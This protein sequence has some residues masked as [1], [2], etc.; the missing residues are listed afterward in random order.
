[1][2]QHHLVVH[3]LVLRRLTVLR[4]RDVTPRMRRVTVGG[5]ELG[6]F[7]RDGL[8]LQAFASTQFDDHVKIVFNA[9][10]PAEDVVPIQLEHGIEWTDAPS[11]RARDYTPRRVAEDELDVDFVL[12]S[13]R[14]GGPAEQWARGAAPGD[15]LWIVGPKSSTVLPSDVDRMILVA[16]ETGLPAVGR[17]FDERPADVPVTA[18]LTVADDRARQDLAVGP[19]DS[20]V[21]VNAAP[22]DGAALADAVATLPDE[23]WQ[24][25]PYVWAAGESRSLLP[26]R[27]LVGRT[28]GVPKD[29]T[30]IT[31]Y[32]HV[33][34]DTDDSAAPAT[35][36]IE[37]PVAWLAVRAAVRLGVLDAIGDGATTTAAIGDRLTLPESV[38][39]PLVDV[40]VTRGV[41][42][43]T[44]GT[45]GLGSLGDDLLGDEHAREY[46]DGPF[47]DGVLTLTRLPDALRSGRSAWQESYGR[48]LAE[49]AAEDPDLAGEFEEEAARLTFLTGGIAA[50]PV[51]RDGLRVAVTGPGAEPVRRGL[52][53]ARPV[54]FVDDGA[55]LV[56]SALAGEHRTDDELR[57]HLAACDAPALVLVES[58]TP[59]A[60]GA[61]RAEEMLLRVATT[62]AAYRTAER[63]TEI[64][65]E[66]GWRTRSTRSLGWGVGALVLDRA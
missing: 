13:A 52:A 62:G 54:H 3:P 50:L 56:V 15:D 16:D 12:H 29:H 66:A 61:H 9:D 18:V 57:S 49:T 64:A 45:L 10:G 30:N 48:T 34:T 42:T 35:P 31:G 51:W 28:H 25:T 53:D 11:R 65:G 7:R 14:G 38:L 36:P 8:D 46:F 20:V 32:W 47:A 26:L 40:L 19:H 2:S 23:V 60:L 41:L 21:W 55:D 63:L 43:E 59:D 44:A 24:G 27:R 6:A 1:M 5:D 22:G 33:T 4:V 37:A 58:T 39:A 17:F